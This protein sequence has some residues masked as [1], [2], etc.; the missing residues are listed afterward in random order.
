MIVPFRAATLRSSVV[1]FNSACGNAAGSSQT[2]G[3]CGIVFNN[4]F[5]QSL[6][7][8]FLCATHGHRERKKKGEE[9]RGISGESFCRVGVFRRVKVAHILW[10]SRIARN[11]ALARNSRDGLLIFV[12]VSH[13][14]IVSMLSARICTRPNEN[15]PQPGFFFFFVCGLGTCHRGIRC[16]GL[17]L[18]GAL[19]NGF[20]RLREELGAFVLF[21]LLQ[22]HLNDPCMGFLGRRRAHRLC[23]PT[24][25]AA[26][27]SWLVRIASGRVFKK[28]AGGGWGGG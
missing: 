9:I 18:K 8:V 21:N 5:H 24:P 12:I 11:L 17:Q 22:T 4:R 1:V 20:E 13:N 15:M 23:S 19:Q 7:A 6:S 14:R 25:H 16:T 2:G 26:I 10:A 28:G 3:R 27:V